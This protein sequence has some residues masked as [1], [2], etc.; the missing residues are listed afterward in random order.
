MCRDVI[1]AAERLLAFL[2]VT[3]LFIGGTGFFKTYM[4]SVLLGIEPSMTIC[5]A[6]FLV[7]FSVYTLDKLV[8][9][10]RDV[11]NMPARKQF[12]Y[13]RRKIFM[14]L[15]LSAYITAALIM[16]YVR[17]QALP[18][19]F[20]PV[21]ANAFYGMRLLPWLPRLK[22]IPVMKNVVVG[23]AWAVVTVLIPVLDGGYSSPWIL[24]L[25]FIF[26]KTFIDTVLYDIRDLAGDRLSGVR[27]MPVIL[28]EMP[29]VLLLL[30]LNTTIL[31]VSLL[32][33]GDG[34]AIALA[35]TLYGYAYIAYL[36]RRRNPVVLDLL[37]EG[38]WMMAC[39]V[40]C[41]LNAA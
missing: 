7:S 9:L 25:Y 8:D 2:A 22:D 34:R 3:S 33:P 40:L 36:R 26:I 20:V 24:V 32:L 31:P 18:L 1:D 35:L 6:V 37:V 10:D 11:S 19:V 17:P 21:I 30:I 14:G 23:S 13:S 12:L 39:A 16:V 29:T 38:E 5:L 27:T 41:L 4:A 28:G 15:A